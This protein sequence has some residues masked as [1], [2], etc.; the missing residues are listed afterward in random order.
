MFVCMYVYFVLCIYVCIVLI[1]V[2]TYVHAC[3]HNIC[4]HACNVLVTYII[5]YSSLRSVTIGYANYIIL[6]II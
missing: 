1:H 3:K 2:C 4:M 5:G 6:H